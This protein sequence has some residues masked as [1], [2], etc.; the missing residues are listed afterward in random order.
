[1]VNKHDEMGRIFVHMAAHTKSDGKRDDFKK[2]HTG[3]PI[4]HSLKRAHTRR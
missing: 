4:L 3:T 2:F 1:M